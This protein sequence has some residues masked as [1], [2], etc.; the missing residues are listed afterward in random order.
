MTTATNTTV[1]GEYLATMRLLAE[2]MLRSHQEIGQA[3][4][5]CKFLNG[6]EM[7]TDI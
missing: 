1:S 5:V 3:I 6:D 2:E 7:S 4:F